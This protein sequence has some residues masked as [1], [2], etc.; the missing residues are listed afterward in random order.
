[1]DRRS[2]AVPASRVRA[3]DVPRAPPRYGKRS[4]SGLEAGRRVSPRLCLS[5]SPIRPRL[6]P[7]G[8]WPMNLKR[9]Q[10]MRLAGS[11]VVGGGCAHSVGS[12]TAT[13]GTMQLASSSTDKWA[14]VRAE[15]DQDPAYLN[16]TGFLLTPHPRRVREAIAAHRDAL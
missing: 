15:F 1:M 13:S 8:E 4:P 7:N 6:A 12:A 11:A 16:F 5:A 9:R 14:K 3:P 2:L 10:F